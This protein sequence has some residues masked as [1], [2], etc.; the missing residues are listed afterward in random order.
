MKK[1]FML[2]TTL[3]ILLFSVIVLSVIYNTVSNH[4]TNVQRVSSYK[5]LELHVSNALQIG[6]GYVRTA[7]SGLLGINLTTTSYTPIWWDEFRTKL[8]QNWRD[9]VD[10]WIYND[11]SF[12]V[13]D[14]SRGIHSNQILR[15]EFESYSAEY[16]LSDVAVYV[17][18]F[19]NTKMRMFVVA[20]VVKDNKSVYSY[21]VVMPELLNK[22]VYF[23]HDEGENI[24]FTSRTRIYGP[25]R[26]NSMIR[27]NNAGGKPYFQ[28]TVEVP[29][30]IRHTGNPREITANT[31]NYDQIIRSLADFGG[32]PAYRLISDAERNELD[33]TAIKD[34]YKQL[35]NNHF[36]LE[37]NQFKNNSTNPMGLKITSSSNLYL[38]V[39]ANTSKIKI[40]IGNTKYEISWTQLPDAIV[41]IFAKQGSNWRRTEGPYSVKFNGIIYSTENINLGDTSTENMSY[42]GNLTLFSEKDINIYRRIITPTIQQWLIQNLGPNAL[43]TAVPDNKIQELLSY[44]EQNETSSLNIVAGNNV[45]IKRK[46]NNMK[47]VA[48]IY[49]FDGQ[50]T[51]EN[52]NQGSPKGQLFV[53]GS[54]M[55]KTRGPVG[56]FNPNTGQTRTGYYHGYVH[57]PRILSGNYTPA[58]TPSRSSRI[59]VSVFGIVR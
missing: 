13:F 31:P 25:F 34:E 45:V 57:D 15:D 21:A 58:G 44:V 40:V 30:F 27:I 51:V 35:L 54:I 11:K 38:S 1:G 56:T 32:N 5:E 10:Q 17:F 26:S 24:W 12:C 2:P 9:Y 48:S 23:S 55:Q 33:F 4:M 50:F 46:L 3:L 37:I 36:V 47:I 39:D 7:S 52:Y 53:L 41:E 43:S 19:R 16:N 59:S 18:P 6:I 8:D 28:D 29:G 22:Y 42:S 14:K 20:R 49:A